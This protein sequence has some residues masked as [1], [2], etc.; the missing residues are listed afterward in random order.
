MSAVPI[1]QSSLQYQKL[2]DQALIQRM[3]SGYHFRTHLHRTIEIFICLQGQIT[4]AV[5]G[6]QQVVSPG[7]YL[8]I[9]PNIPHNSIVTSPGE[10]SILQMHFHAAPLSDLMGQLDNLSSIPFLLELSLGKR[11]YFKG[12]STPALQSCL[13]GIRE[14]SNTTR[15]NSA[16]MIW[17]YFIQM[18]ILLSRDLSP[19]PSKWLYYESPHLIKATSFISQHYMEKLYVQDIASAVGISSRYLSQLFDSFLNMGVSAY[20][21]FVRISKAIDIKYLHPECSLQELA[22]ETGFSSQQHFSKIFKE[23]MTVSPRQYFSL[24]AAAEADSAC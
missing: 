2:L 16:D 19:S 4:V 20:I 7:E 15:K 3:P 1:Y 22:L 13:E 14:E 21:N 17:L 8:V 5:H 12:V 24:I 18:Y 6:L 9:F 23:I 10:C 11:M